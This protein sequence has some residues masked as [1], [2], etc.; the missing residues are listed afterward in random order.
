MLRYLLVGLLGGIGLASVLYFVS[1]DAAGQGPEKAKSTILI[2][3]DGM[4][5]AH[6]DAV[7]LAT[8]G[9]DDRISMNKLPY[10]GM[11]DTTP[12]DPNTIVTDSAAGG[13]AFASGV[14]TRNGAVGVGPENTPVPTI[15]EE[16]KRA[17]KAT[18][19]V[20]TDSVTSATPA[21]FAA[22][23]ENRD[24]DEEI[25]RQYVEETQPDVILGGGRS[26][27]YQD[28][29]P[30]DENGSETGGLVEDAQLRGYAYTTDAEELDRTGKDKILGLFAEDKMFEE[31][32]EGEGSYDPAVS[33]PRMTEKAIA[34]LSRDPEGFFLVVEEEAID[35]MSHENNSEL[36]IEAGQELDKAV[37]I[38]QN[39]VREEPDTLL[40]VGADH[41]TGGLTV[42]DV[43]RPITEN[44]P[45]GEDGPFEIEGSTHL[46]EL[47]WS[48]SSHTA[49]DVPITATGPGAERLSGVY[50]NTHVYEVMKE[51]LLSA[52]VGSTLNA[53]NILLTAVML[54]LIAFAILISWR[55]MRKK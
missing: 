25:A 35:E 40:I 44:E 18:G 28:E 3:G 27:F 23:V 32:P 51:S 12:E 33:L 5:A 36:M 2:I 19:L 42:E 15:L 14:K 49:V 8:V 43:D 53:R 54:C 10:A 20:T 48:T 4:G 46:F 26:Y 7:Q 17:G 1:I 6:R 30:G 24:Q 52:S 29:E 45:S 34:T 37:E 50:D 13:V 16:A 39:Y 55:L 47:D 21:V 41:E 31:G 38:A 22:H 9:S 11:S